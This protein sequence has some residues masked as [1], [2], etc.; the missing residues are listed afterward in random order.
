MS[1]EQSEQI[2]L[3][4]NQILSLAELGFQVETHY[5]TPQDI[6]WAI[7]DDQLYL[8]QTRPITSLFPIDGLTSPDESL[9]VYLSMGHQQ[10]MMDA[11]SPLGLSTIQVMMPVGHKDD[12]FDN[13]VIKG[14]WGADVCKSYSPFTASSGA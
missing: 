13:S 10:S 11:M 1:K 14:K 8:L 3:S 6:E 4:D 5:G 12:E 2:V 7:K 9:Q